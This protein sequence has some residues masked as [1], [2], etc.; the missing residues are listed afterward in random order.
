MKRR[1]K[2][3]M[4]ARFHEFMNSGYLLMLFEEF[5]EGKFDYLI[6]F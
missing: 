1:Y 6:I 5:C 2:E 4:K 3:F